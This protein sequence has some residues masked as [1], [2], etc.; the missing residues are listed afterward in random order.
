M[1]LETR[2]PKSE[3]NEEVVHNKIADFS[4]AQIAYYQQTNFTWK[5]ELKI[6]S[7]SPIDRIASF[8]HEINTQFVDE[9]DK[10]AVVTLEDLDESL[11][12]TDFQ[13]VYR[14]EGVNA[15]SV[16]AQINGKEI[17]LAISLL[18]DLTP[19]KE[20]DRRRPIYHYGPDFDSTSRYFKG[21]K[22]IAQEYYFVL[23]RS[24]SMK[25]K[26][27][28]VAKVALNLFI[29][30]LP[31]GS[32]FNIISFGFD[33]KKVFSSAKKYTEDSLNEAIEAVENF[34]ANLGGTEIYEPLQNI[35]DDSSASK[36]HNKHVF[37]IT[38][39][40][41]FDP[42]QI[43]DLIEENNKRYTT[44][45]FGIGDGVSTELIQ[46]CASAGLGTY[47][48]VNNEAH[49]LKAKIITALQKTFVP[50]FYV[51]KQEL[52]VPFEKKLEYPKLKQTDK[53]YHGQYSTYLTVLDTSEFE[54]LQGKFMLKL[55]NSKSGEFKSFNLDISEKCKIIEGDS[56]FKLTAKLAIDDLIK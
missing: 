50:F 55:S 33:Y 9:E 10:I 39:G 15:P 18:A 8:S 4:K 54:E 3:S 6:E 24:G 14:N 21:N 19:Q 31:P 36:K 37:L 44:H 48:Y 34:Q 41:V 47:S 40:N 51:T 35:F 22:M 23:D 1:Y 53:F 25:G 27:I 17:A 49:G 20:V 43:I 29:R 46:Q 42:Q 5:F 52:D 12:D 26:P 13:L 30:S 32:K 2:N 28:E 38:D 11:F 45:T 7:D 16:L 56:I